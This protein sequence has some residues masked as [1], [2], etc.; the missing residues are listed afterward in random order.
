MIHTAWLC[1]HKVVNEIIIGHSK[2]K[3]YIAEKIR[4]G[5]TYPRERAKS[6]LNKGTKKSKQKISQTQK[7]W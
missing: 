5:G 7:S 6:R 2:T 1:E 4:I 3:K